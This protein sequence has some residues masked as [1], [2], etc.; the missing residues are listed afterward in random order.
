MTLAI[1]AFYGGHVE[2]PNL[3]FGGPPAHT[4][5]QSDAH[6]AT[7]YDEALRF[8]E[9]MERTGYD[10]LW[11][12]EH[13]FQREGYG[14]I[15]NVPLLSLHLAN[16]TERLKF[17]AF[18]NTVTAW[19]PL[20][21]AEDYAMVDVLTGGRL[22]FGIGR[23]YVAREVETLGGPLLDDVA[24][25][26]LF[27]EQVEIMLKAW[28]RPEFAHAGV[29]YRVPA[30]VPHMFDD[31]VDITL[32]PRPAHLP[33]EIWQPITSTKRR[34]FDFMARHGI[35]GVIAGGAAPGGRAE[36]AAAL[37]RDALA[38]A[39][40]ETELGEDLAVGIQMHLGDSREAALREATPWAE[41]HLKG[42]APLG[43]Y[44]Q[45]SDAQVRA[46]AQGEAAYK[47]G[48]PTIQDLDAE[49]TWVCGTPNYVRDYL[50][51]LLERLPGLRRVFIQ[52]GSL[53]VPPSAMRADIEWFAQDVMPSVKAAPAA[54]AG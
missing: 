43:R 12:A 4:R 51:G 24:N 45:L 8:A 14:C 54:S 1:D 11:L 37:Y 29:G 22:R 7:V 28:H 13:H 18:F 20:R 19:H 21:L 27:E 2:M 52:T 49:G 23:G 42:L 34:G 15:G 10:T 33:V 50:V 6:L 32:V 48:L 17:G 41:E 5:R 9:L 46:T 30:D 36:Q 47:A 3:G 26:E 16:Q 44:P 40:R 35:K 31:L 25:R 53:G 38:R 39:G